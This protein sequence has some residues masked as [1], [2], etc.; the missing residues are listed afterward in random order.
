MIY[1]IL[2]DV[3][4]VCSWGSKFVTDWQWLISWGKL[5]FPVSL[6]QRSYWS[7]L[8]LLKMRWF[9]G[10]YPLPEL[11]V[12]SVHLY[13]S[14]VIRIIFTSSL[15]S[16]FSN[17]EVHSLLL[18]QSALFSLWHELNVR[19]IPVILRSWILPFRKRKVLGKQHMSAMW[20]FLKVIKS[21][22][23]GTCFNR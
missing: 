17:E 10:K 8:S 5:F 15:V 2:H 13:L 6:F 1:A 7:L 20:N 12:P 21:P 14:D 22:F 9:L 3:I 19:E 4:M 23:W 16:F 11:R 18:F